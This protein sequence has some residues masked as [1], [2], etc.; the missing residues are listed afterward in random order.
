MKSAHGIT[1]GD[2]T[3]SAPSEYEN[4]VVDYVVEC[5]V[6]MC[7]TGDV[8]FKKFVVLLTNGYEPSSTRTFLRRKVELY[9]ILEPLSATFLCNLDVA[10]SLTLDGWSN[11]NLKGF[12]II[13]AHWVDVASLTNKSIL[14]TILDVKCGINVNKHVRAALFEYLKRLGQ[15]V[16]TCLLNVVNNNGSDATN[17]VAR[18]FQLVNTFIGYEQM[19]KVNHVQCSDHSV[20][21]AMLKV[22][23]FIKEPTEQLRDALIRIRCSKVMWQQFRVEVTAAK[24]AS[25]QPTHQDSP[26]RWK[27]THEMCTNASNKRVILDNIMDQYTAAI[28]HGVLPNLEWHAIDGVSTFLHM[29]RQ[30]MESLAA[31][32]KPMLDLVPMSV[33]LLLKHCDD[34][35]QQLQE[36][37]NKLTTVGVKAK[38][39]KYKS[40][41]VQ[42]PM[43]IVAYQCDVSGNDDE[44]NQ[45]LLIGVVQS[46]GFINI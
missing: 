23:T 11:H 33:S 43:I 21:L 40:K 7:V 31:N 12:Y 9:R 32:H 17:A 16:V 14:L 46:L 27:S 37:D 10:I 20:Q 44:V 38:L 42:E 45:Y 29:P 36:I 5:G 2:I 15:D 6:T 18:L 30:V 41:L 22:L 25:K 3:S 4:V 28:G 19:C 13:I 24:L 26:T 39:E 8:Y 34:N 1:G 35:E